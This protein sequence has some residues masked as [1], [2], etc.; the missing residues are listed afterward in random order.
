MPEVV[1]AL[2]LDAVV[3]PGNSGG[4]VYLPSSG[5]VVG[6]CQANVP[7]P[8]R[9]QDGDAVFVQRGNSQEILEQNAGIAVVIPIRYAILLLEKHKVPY[10]R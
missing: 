8:I 10:E 9:F 7:S 2:F 6:I 4:P 5:V 3:N 1:D